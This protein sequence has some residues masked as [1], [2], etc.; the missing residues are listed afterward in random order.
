MN[1]VQ[2]NLY[3]LLTEFDSICK[4]HG[5][6]YYI[7][8][9]NALGAVRNKQFLPWDDDIDLYMTRDEWNKLKKLLETEENILPEGRSFVY[10]ENTEYYC[11]TIPRYVDTTTTSIYKSQVLAGKACGQNIEIF[12]LDPMPKG[13]KE[14][15]EYV[16]LLRVYTEL[17]T[18]YYVVNFNLNLDEWEKHYRLYEEYHNRIK[19]EGEEKV[20]RELEERLQGY[21]LKECDSLCMCWG[22][23]ILIYKKEY[24]QP[25][26]TEKFEDQY[27]PV[28][29]KVESALRINFGD[30]WMYVPEYDNQIVHGGLK[31]VNVPLNEYTDI[32]LNKINR[33]SIIEKYKR[34]K[35]NNASLFYKREK[36]R[37]LIAKANAIVK[38]K[39]I[40]EYLD[41]KEEYLEDLLKN[42]DYDTLMNEFKDYTDLQLEKNIRKN[43]ILVPISDKILKKLILALTEE[44]K[45]FEA[46]K[47]L[48]IRKAQDEPMDEEFIEINNLVRF[49]R[50]LSIARY[51]KKDEDLVL[52]L[53]EENKNKYPD[54]LDIY[55]CEIWIKENNAES[56][57]DFKLIDDLCEKVLEIYPFDGETM[58]Y[59]AR[60][61]MECGKKEEAMELYNKSIENTRNGL[62]WKKVEE[63]SGISRIDIEREMIME[64]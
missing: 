56:T 39:R 26:R 62:I 47:Y 52:S 19:E 57:E 35:E 12:V 49:C 20:I 28:V 61:K 32:Y 63:E 9:G 13:E 34:N 6:E 64:K 51:D 25:G 43:K 1:T 50:K 29:K 21:S 37:M 30:D 27:F 45:Y 54:L 48:D 38:S 53:I 16:D 3:Q 41:S 40:V 23:Y 4:K 17:L 24:I 2:K 8:A 58:A 7:A 46:N 18:P 36:N 33:K 42:K 44:G 31:D 59:H 15:E 55:R 11:N 14:K 60:A 5:L 22:N 10:N